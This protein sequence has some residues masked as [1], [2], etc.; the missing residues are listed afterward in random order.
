MKIP[1]FC[2]LIAA[3]AG[4]LL[5]NESPQEMLQI[6]KRVDPKY[7]AILK[8]AGIEG[9]VDLKLA[10]NEQ[11]K[12]DKA[13]AVK[14]SNADFIPAAM[15]AVKQWEFTPATDNGKPIKA[16]VL[17]PF[18]FRLGPDSYKSGS[19]ALFKLKDDAL[20]ILRGE[21]TEELKSLVD[22]ESY[23]VIGGNFEHLQSLLADRHKST[24]LV[25]G[26]ATKI[27]MSR[28]KT[29]DKKNTAYLILKTKPGPKRANR[30]HTIVFMQNSP[31]EWKLVSWHAS[32]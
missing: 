4:I 18:K 3:S 12:V 13:E 22:V 20:R 15:E 14:A 24:L 7:P 32:Q 27:E 16:E 31:G 2:F 21:L 23:A 6:K 19:E 17:I 26:K 11:G 9:D 10:V 25:E 8:Q 28:L 30:F 1:R 5:A 29:D